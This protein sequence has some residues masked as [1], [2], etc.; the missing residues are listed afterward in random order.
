[1]TTSL[2]GITSLSLRYS[3]SS[4]AIYDTI[5]LIAVLA[6]NDVMLQ[7]YLTSFL[8]SL[9]AGAAVLLA[10]ELVYRATQNDIAALAT[11]FTIF[12]YP[13]FLT[14]EILRARIGFAAIYLV[15]NDRYL[16]AAIA[17][18]LAAGY[19]QFAVIFLVVVLLDAYRT[20]SVRLWQP[21]TAMIG[22]TAVVIAPILLLGGGEA[23]LSQVI[24]S[25]LQIGD[26]SADLIDRIKKFQ[27]IVPYSWPLFY[28]ACLITIYHVVSDWREAWWLSLGLGW[29]ALQI[30]Y[31]DFDAAPG[32][33]SSSS[34]ALVPVCSSAD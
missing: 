2:I 15:R 6:P 19:R 8:T 17:G 27:D 21:V 4:S 3:S 9:M 11:G 18:A 22:T 30:G 14:V 16:L 23:M 32:S 7:Y 1:M 29:A 24:I 12:A 13:H 25:S 28:V 20:Q 5:A 33:C 34:P 26:Q 10:A 31:L